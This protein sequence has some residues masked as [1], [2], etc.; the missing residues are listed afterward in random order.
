MSIRKILLA[1]AAA[2]LLAAPASAATFR[3]AFQGDLNALDPYTLNETFTLGALG[4]VMEGLT[5]RDKDLKIIPGL[6]ERWETSDDGRRWRFYLRR[7]VKYHDGSPFTA[8]DVIFSAER[9]QADGSQVK[10]RL[11]DKFN[12]EKVDDHTVDFVMPEPNPILHYEWDTWYIFS[13]PWADKVGAT[14]PQ[15]ATAT[16]LNAWALT[17]NGT[18]PFRLESHQPGVKTVFKPNPDWWGKPEHNLTEV[19]FTTIKS[20]ATRVA[21]LLSG[22][23]DMMDPVPVQDIERIK[24]SP[25]VTVMTGPELRTIFLNMDSFRDELLY[26]NV[27]GKNPFKDARVRKAF[28]QAID[29]E[30]I[31]SRVMRGNSAPSSILI[32]PLLFSRAAEIKRH[33]YDV[34]ASKKLLAEAGYPNG[35]EV[36]IDCP[37][38][39]YVN[40][41]AI[42]QAVA[43]MLARANVKVQL[44]AQPK[45]KYFEK[46]GPTAKYDSSFNLLGWTPG[47]FDSWN[48]LGNITHC[49]DA[50]GK[51]GQFNYGGYCNPKVDELAD[52]IL[53]ESDTAK[54]DAMILEAFKIVHEEAGI[55][56][57]HQQTLAWGV[58]KKTKIVQRADNQILLYWVNKE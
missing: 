49:R 17:A 50:S 19:I 48:V 8:D 45:A 9:A 1:A 11:P 46:A 18:G 10:S 25:N 39:R 32:S 20:D 28:Y 21:A 12:I 38:D 27:K 22:E 23:I 54:R 44:N 47:S 14:K 51:G 4:N 35:F 56:P 24:S 34:E 6:A 40:D 42:C 30:A 41:E 43:A 52:K 57:L 13:K 37:N 5:K 55:I 16:S 31:K 58:S 7:N 3:Y 33:P 53:V 36:T 2:T 29:I 26:S 15:S